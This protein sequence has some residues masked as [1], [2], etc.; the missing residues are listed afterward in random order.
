MKKS[1][2]IIFDYLN[3]K[4][5][6]Q[7]L[8][9]KSKVIG[10]T[11][12]EITDALSLQRTNVS[13]ILNKLCNSGKVYKIKGKPIIYAVAVTDEMQKSM[14]VQ[15]SFE[16]LIGRNGSLKKCI[17][18]AKA[19]ILYPPNGLHTLLLG[20]TGVGKTMFA[21]LMYKFT[22]E[23]SV[24][25]QGAPFVAFNCS[26]YANN[27][28]LLLAHLFGC[29]KGAFTGA[30][31]DRLG[32]VDKANDGI[33][34][35]D[36][37]HRLPPEGQEMLFMLIDKGVYTPLGDID[38]KKSSKVL[39][40]CATTEDADSTLLSTFTRRIPITI[41]IPS[42]K[43]RTLNERFELIGGF[44]KTESTRIG[45]EITVSADAIRALL[46][47]N[48]TGNIGQLKSD[49]QLGCAN[50]FLKY[51][52]KGEKNIEVHSTDFSSNVRHG[53]VM[54]KQ[55]SQKVD[56]IIRDDMK[57][58]F[59]SK[60]TKLHVESNY[61][62][63]PNNFYESIE[64]RIQELKERGVEEEDI[65]FIMSFDI[66]NYFNKYI[67]KFEQSV[68]KKE[69]SKIVDNNIIT[70]VEDF[71]KT[72]SEQLKRIFQAK[73]FYG[74]CLHISS[75]IERILKHKKIVNYNLEEI[76]Q[77]HGEEY[78]L[79]L[80]IANKLEEEFNIKIP[81]DEVGFMAMFLCIDDID[82]AAERSKPII[83]VAMHGKNTA[84]SMAEV[85]NKL[86]GGDNI[87]AY[88]MNLDKKS[89]IAYREL[90]DLIV[91]NHQG[92]G[93]MLL[94]D[95]GSLGM[96]GELITEETG[97]EIRVIDMV[98][99]LL[100]IECLRKA[101]TINN[102]HQIYEEVKYSISFLNKYN[103]SLTQTYMPS[104][105]NIIITNCITGEGSAI[106]LKN[107]IEEKVNLSNKDIEVIAISAGDKKE[108]YNT[109][110][111]LS[112]GKKIIAIV[113]TVNPNIYDIPFIPTSELFL[114]SSYTRI[115]NIVERIKIPEDIYK[116]IFES[117]EKEVKELNISDFKPL[118]VNLIDTIRRNITTNLDIYI[119]SGFILHLACA[120]VRMINKEPTSVCSRREEIK[121]T[122]IKEYTSL[123]EALIS[124]ESHY[125]IQFSQD[126]LC[127]MLMIILSI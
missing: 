43:E 30:D 7:R 45:K 116:D 51:V 39:I 9:G 112:K 105:D 44:F 88:D 55:Y 93:V 75:S 68:N 110:N 102:I 32:L 60:G 127:Y 95:M 94:V 31:R 98:S 53:L 41:N 124:I 57:L 36:E 119:V 123:K 74:L 120:V 6:K 72:A 71:L 77:K 18:Q 106:K 69:L 62:L 126:E 10:C 16:T 59:N 19:A 96:F 121:N 25:P 15:G 70:I 115:K 84:S 103:T 38:K 26:D 61:D 17:Q 8:E 5:T 34:F 64:K 48:C 33:L 101:Q 2:D 58:S 108:M 118:C 122:Y 47:Y 99:T 20:P 73:V 23:K 4:C 40:I 28:Q 14:K 29:K 100:V 80:I 49:I 91:E 67:R 21:E 125:N 46:L 79:A 114:D 37:I 52:S 104:K 117:L 63:L 85:A 83:V 109:I 13:T 24:F 76:I 111:V 11:T 56:E 22:I 12:K 107:M 81:A 50:A 82:E 86:V 35:L 42:L 66:K 27:S 90:K 54:Y 97:I 65:D 78:G 89:E 92:A 3:D 87:Y 1:E 113:G